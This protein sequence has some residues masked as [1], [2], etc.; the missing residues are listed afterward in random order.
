[1]AVLN[2]FFSFI[3]GMCV[4]IMSLFFVIIDWWL[5]LVPRN[6]R[7]LV[8]RKVLIIPWTIIANNFLFCM[9]LKVLGK[10]H[11]NKLKNSLIICNHQSWADIP[12]FLRFTPSTA[13]SKAEVKKIPL[14]G[15]LT[16]YAGG[17]FFDRDDKKS[18]LGIIKEVME[19]LK[20]GYSM[21]YYPEGTRSLD[22]ELLEPNLTLVKLAYKLKVP[23]IPSAIEGSKNVIKK[24]R[25]Y[26]KFF[27]KVV[28]KY[29][30][31]LYPA[32]Y[33]SDEEFANACWNKVI[34]THNE[35][36]AEYFGK[37]S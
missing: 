17:I 16:I 30:E 20:Q 36:K 37:K 32:D 29:V 18:R 19:F 15:I 10:E 14:V 5:L 24:G 25:I 3:S 6:K 13:L 26:Y 4:L 22:G 11:A 35:I 21:C 31:P 9:R 23:V 8:A 27:Q 34:D 2:L 28:L 33:K 12:A 7:Y 1:M